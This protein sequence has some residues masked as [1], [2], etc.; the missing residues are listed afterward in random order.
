MPKSASSTG[1]PPNTSEVVVKALERFGIGVAFGM[2]GMWSLPLYDALSTSKIRHILVRHEQ[3]AVYAADGYARVSGK[4]GFCIGTAGPGAVNIAAGMAVPYRDHS[5]VIAVTGQVP[6]YEQGKGWIEDLD[7]QAIFKPITKFTAQVTD[8]ASAYDLLATA[9]LSSVEGCPGPSHVSVPGDVQ[10]LPSRAKDYIPVPSKPEPDPATIDLVIDAVSSSRVPLILAGWGAVQSGASEGVMK[11]AE[12]IRS[13]VATSY[14]GRGIIPED[15][16]LALGP[17]G[18]RG[19]KAANAAL[20]SCDL[21]IALGCR[22]TNLTV[23]TAINCKV[24]QVDVDDGNFSVLAS[25]K[26]RSDVSLFIDAVLPRL[27]SMRRASTPVARPAGVAKEVEGKAPEFARALSSF[28]DAIFS[29]DIGQHTIWLMQALKVKRPR[30]VLFSGNLSAMGYS[31]PA[32]IGAK[33][34]S[35]RSKV[36][37]VTGDGGF[38]MTAP[39]LSTMKENGINV[40]VC[41][42][43]NRS[44]GLIRQLQERT[45]GRSHGVDYSAPPDY[46]KLAEAYGVMGIKADSPSDVVDA[47]RVVDEPIVVEIPIPRKEGVEMSRPRTL[48]KE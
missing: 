46:V 44:L 47:L 8:P 16:R 6:T 19:T 2:P 22:L 21:L 39:E 9:F 15:S 3:F 12:A 48:D 35:P 45:Y 24:I 18:R 41:V 1:G 13:P 17:A 40:A 14:M 27:K 31:L 30:H 32:A 26:V 42:F 38:Q 11:L 37:V 25:I 36:I 34:A 28:S 43:N 29:V 23:D 20:A 5:P 4:P 7:L 10:K 33:A